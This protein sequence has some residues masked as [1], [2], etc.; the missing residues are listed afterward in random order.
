MSR[1]EATSGDSTHGHCVT[2]T[3]RPCA[4]FGHGPNARITMALLSLVLVAQ[5][6]FVPPVYAQ[7]DAR[8]DA[9]VSSGLA[10]LARQQSDDGS[11]DT[12]GPKIATTGIALI[13]Y[14]SAGHTPEVGRYGLTVR[15]AVNYLLSVVPADGYI[16][17]IDG[18]RMYGQGIVT[19]A[20][21]EAY[22]VE[23]DPQQRVRIRAAIELSVSVILKAQ[24]VEKPEP[25]AGGWRYE[26][27]STDSDLSLVGWNLL[28]LRAARNI[29][30]EVPQDSLNRAMVFVLRCYR[31]EPG[32]FAHQPQ[33]EV[34]AGMSALG[35]TLLCLLDSPDRAEVSTSAEFLTSRAG[36]EPARFVGSTVHA[37][38]RAAVLIGGPVGAQLWDSVRDFVLKSQL[39]DG[40]WPPSRSGDEPGRSFSTSMS[41]LALCAPRRTLPAYER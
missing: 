35:V 3:S 7:R 1:A 18:S 21:S 19:L 38:A 20:L 22:G 25:H 33:T 11:F 26:P 34:S 16:G 32:G 15:R 5:V 13:A 14:L 31:A 37:S 10:F 12:V 36:D 24:Q 6:T 4:R 23:H 39:E 29:G 27:Q 8:I 2:R 9:A 41:V 30:V 28:A 17:R 40:G